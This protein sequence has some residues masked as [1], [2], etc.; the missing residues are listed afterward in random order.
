M[1]ICPNCGSWVDEG[2]ICHGC[3]AVFGYG[4]GSYSE[5]DIWQCPAVLKGTEREGI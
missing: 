5:S 1:G 4:G 3:G 2:D